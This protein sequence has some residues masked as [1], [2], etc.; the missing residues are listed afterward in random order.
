MRHCGAKKID[1][2]D[3]LVYAHRILKQF[4]EVLAAYSGRDTVIFQWMRRRILPESSTRSSVSWQ[5]RTG[6][7]LW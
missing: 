6:I 4:P 3:Q 5:N 2:D 7:F 1:Y